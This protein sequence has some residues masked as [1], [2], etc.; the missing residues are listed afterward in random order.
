MKLYRYMSMK[1]FQLLSAG[2]E[3]ENKNTFKKCLTNSE[4]FCFLGEKTKFVINDT[5]EVTFSAQ[6]CRMFLNGIVSDD[7]LV[8]FE[9]ADTTGLKEG[10][11][12][13]ASPYDYEELIR[14]DEYS[15]MSYNRDK[16]V[17]IRYGM[18][19]PFSYTKC[20]WYNFN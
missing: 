19:V 6:E 18:P 9:V 3:L 17:P 12:V 16:F 13:Y 10:F 8:E 14:I 15:V 11:G 20:D 7:I 1:E 2:C 5:E 4:G